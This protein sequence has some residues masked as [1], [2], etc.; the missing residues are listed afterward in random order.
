MHRRIIGFDTFTGFPDVVSDI[1]RVNRHARP[2]GLSVSPGYQ[3]HLEQV[4]AA[5]EAAQPLAHV[6]RTLIFE[7]DV[8][9]T[10]PRYLAANPQTVIALAYFDLDLYEST[11]SALAAVVPYLTSG[12]VLAFDQLGHAKWPGETAALRDILGT[13]AVRL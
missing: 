5:H 10:L 1:D 2:G 8:R 13:R 6:R 9:G 7:G 12:S 11:R 3:D 4:L